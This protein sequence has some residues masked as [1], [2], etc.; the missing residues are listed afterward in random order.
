MVLQ[1]V[2]I[3]PVYEFHRDDF[4]AFR[5]SQTLGMGLSFCT[6]INS[7]HFRANIPLQKRLVL[8]LVLFWNI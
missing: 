1:H 7:P 3:N 4:F 6:T 5:L 2:V 8:M